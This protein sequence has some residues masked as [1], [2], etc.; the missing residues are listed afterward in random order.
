LAET[1]SQ[2]AV[3]PLELICV[4][5]RKPRHFSSLVEFNDDPQT[6]KSEVVGLLEKTLLLAKSEP[7][8]TT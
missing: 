2:E 3:Q 4:V 5:L 1:L 8:H 6:G 7:L